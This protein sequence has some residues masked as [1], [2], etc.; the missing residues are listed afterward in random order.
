MSVFLKNDIHFGCIHI[1]KKKRK[2]KKSVND[3]KRSQKMYIKY[4]KPE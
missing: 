4:M 2:K 1:D 3:K